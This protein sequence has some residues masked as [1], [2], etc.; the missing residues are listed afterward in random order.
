MS[1]A[2]MARDPAV[3]WADTT[4]FI[5]C[6]GSRCEQRPWCSK[7][8]CNHTIMEALELKARNPRADVFVLYRDMTTF[9]LNEPFYEKC[10]KLA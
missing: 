8:C 10:R 4:V 9:G 2:M 6:V 7:V 3:V 1:Q 5:Q